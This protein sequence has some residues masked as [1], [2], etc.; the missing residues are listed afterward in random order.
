MEMKR[1]PP[2]CTAETQHRPHPGRD[3]DQQSKGKAPFQSDRADK[4]RV[5]E[6]KG[7]RHVLALR[8]A[9]WHTHTSMHSHPLSLPAHRSPSPTTAGWGPLYPLLFRS[10]SLG[11]G[12][13][14]PGMLRPS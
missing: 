4:C 7:G 9:L 11:L 2:L 6:Q 3:E 8:M 10:C 12:L 5:E 1:T 13:S 14:P